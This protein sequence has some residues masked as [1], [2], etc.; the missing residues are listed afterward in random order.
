MKNV[1]SGGDVVPGDYIIVTFEQYL[2]GDVEV[3]I[4]V[5]DSFL[6]IHKDRSFRYG[7]EGD[8]EEFTKKAEAIL[9]Y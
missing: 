3:H 6:M 1:D 4:D 7:Y 9:T 8:N 5:N 2:F